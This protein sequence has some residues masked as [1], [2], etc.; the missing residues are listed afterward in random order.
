MGTFFGL[1]FEKIEQIFIENITEYTV[2][3]NEDFQI[4][5]INL[6]PEKRIELKDGAIRKLLIYSGDGYTRKNNIAGYVKK[7]DEIVLNPSDKYTLVSS[8]NGLKIIMKVSPP[9]YDRML[10]T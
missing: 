1:I 5:S 10:M 4:I 6:E 9:I 2:E 8:F 3:T 7:G